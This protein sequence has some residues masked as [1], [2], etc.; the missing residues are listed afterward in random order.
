MSEKTVLLRKIAR[1]FEEELDDR[2][3]ALEALDQRARGGLPRSRDGALPGED[4]AG[5]RQVAGGHRARQ[6]LAEAA[7]G[8]GP[9]D[10]LCLHLA[11]WY[12]EDL[13]HPEY[14]QPY[15][16]QIVQLDPNNV[17]ALRQMAQL[18]RKS[19][20]WQQL[21]AT[22]TRALDVAVTD[23]DRKEIL[24]ELGELLDGADEP[25]RPGRHLLP[26][27]ARGRCAASC[28]PSRTWSASTPRESQSRELADILARKVPG[29]LRLRRDR[30]HE[31]AHRGARRV[32]PRRADAGRPGVP[33]GARARRR[34]PARHARAGAG[35][36]AA[37]S[38]GRS[39]CESSRC[40]LD[41]V[42]TERERIDVLLQIAS[43]QE[44]QFLKPDLAAARL[45]QVLEIDPNHEAALFALERNYRRL[46]QWLD[47]IS[48]YDRHIDAT[49][50]PARRRSSSG[51]TPP[52]CYAEEVAGP[53]AGDRRVP[54][55]RRPRRHEHA[56]RSRRSRSSTS[57]RA[58][59]QKAIESMTRVA[60]LTQDPKQR[61][62]MFYRIGK[63]L[64]EKLGRRAA[65][66]ER[67]EMALDLDPAHLPTLA[68]LRVI[69]MDAADYD[70][71]ARYFDQEQS[72]TEAPRAKGAS[73][74]RAR[75]ATRRDARR[76]RAGRAPS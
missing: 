62:E 54:E 25:D 3:Q 39:S 20:N 6:R 2:E 35:L 31:A 14:A 73:S 41:V 43:L 5:D 74:R 40:E 11:K 66:Q 57:S 30:E 21:G 72:Y 33:R 58:T 29:A 4:R 75:Q 10:P 67:Y 32:Q 26:A 1:V 59:P 28:Q 34:E 50:R 7:D 18:Y 63:A 46:R 36:R 64:D 61:V 17:G 55:H 42:T 13:G 53:R 47:L 65:A 68:A 9:E 27:R 12:G 71:A 76:A 70:K 45:E 16:A 15:Y 22:L 49:Q 19:A 44:E 52:R 51:G 56:R 69:A 60:E 48:T 24:T 38:S 37:G 23:V 8:S